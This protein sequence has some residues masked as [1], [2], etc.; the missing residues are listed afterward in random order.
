MSSEPMLFPFVQNELVVVHGQ[1][2][3]ILLWRAGT[4][5][6]FVVH[7]FELDMLIERLITARTEAEPVITTVRYLERGE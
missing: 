2:D 6:V 4:E 5:R 7:R 1:T 3:S